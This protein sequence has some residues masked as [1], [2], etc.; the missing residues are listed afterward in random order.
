MVS[1]DL[2]NKIKDNTI[3]EIEIGDYYSESDVDKIVNSFNRYLTNLL[4]NLRQKF[5]NINC[6]FFSI[7]LQYPTMFVRSVSETE[8]FN[9]IMELKQL[10]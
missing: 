1:D 5:E 3:K 10:W 6:T 8:I 2:R 9:V 7:E 4:I